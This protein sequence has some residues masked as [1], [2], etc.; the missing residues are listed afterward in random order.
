MIR[1]PRSSFINAKKSILACSNVKL[2]Q[3]QCLDMILPELI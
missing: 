2:S 1:D 3:A